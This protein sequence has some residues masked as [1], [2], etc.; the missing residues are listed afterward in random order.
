VVGVATSE[1]ATAPPGPRGQFLA[2]NLQAYEEDRLAF[3]LA[4]ERDYGPIVTFD[5]RTTI[6]NDA[7]RVQEMLHDRS[8]RFAIR[9]NFLLEDIPEHELHAWLGV[10]R[11][12]NP[13]L[14]RPR[15]QGFATVVAD[16]V[17][18]VLG[19]VAGRQVVAVD[20]LEQITSR[21]MARYCFGH[22][23][24]GVPEAAGRLLDA[25]AEVVG[26][27]FALPPSMPTPA[28]R[29]IRRRLRELKALLEPLVLAR[30]HRPGDFGDYAATVID[31]RDE[32]RGQTVDRVLM[33][34][35]GT[36]LAA[37]RVPAAATAWALKLSRGDA[38]TWKALR[39]E[40][41]AHL[42]RRSVGEGS[43]LTDLPV[44]IAVVQESLRLYPPTWL[45]SREATTS[46]QV[47][48]YWFAAGH[49][50][51]ISPYVL[52]RQ[53]AAFPDPEGFRPERWQETTPAMR[54]HYLPFGAG[55]RA[56]P[57]SHLAMVMMTSTLLAAARWDV[58][59]GGDG[60]RADPRTTLLPNG[61]VLEVVGEARDRWSGG[62]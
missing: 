9:Q 23:D 11:L 38:A 55:G 61:L 59:V 30:M 7:E 39:L 27:P 34:L 41:E 15:V 8:G 1:G 18:E 42:A 50:F 62:R 22:E 31:G 20:L 6:V 54:A 37:H 10:R 5:R 28:R 35:I 46:V 26:N 14:R 25:L 12:F 53:S 21:A 13:G 36:M 16:L 17:D 57:G 33:T 60:V 4:A 47:G 58:R 32:E 29:R 3:L 19:G 49:Q 56:C 43:A 24:R 51:L 45:L 40:S 48:G 2:G 52:H 44:T